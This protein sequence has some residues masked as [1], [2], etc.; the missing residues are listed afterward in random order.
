MFLSE[1]HYLG[2]RKPNKRIHTAIKHWGVIFFRNLQ[3]KHIFSPL[4]FQEF[5]EK[6]VTILVAKNQFLIRIF[7]KLSLELLFLVR[8]LM[9]LS[10]NFMTMLINIKIR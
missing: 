6:S 3:D 4:R 2:N 10:R 7:T 5:G 1:Y 8:I 9:K